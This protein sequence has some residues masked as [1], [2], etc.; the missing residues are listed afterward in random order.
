[1]KLLYEHAK[2]FFFANWFVCNVRCRGEEGKRLSYCKRLFWWTKSEGMIWEVGVW[3]DAIVDESRLTWSMNAYRVISLSNA[4]SI[5]PP[6]LILLYR[7]L[8]FRSALWHVIVFTLYARH[9]R[10]LPVLSSLFDPYCEYGTIVVIREGTTLTY[11]PSSSLS[12]TSRVISCNIALSRKRRYVGNLWGPL[13]L[14]ISRCPSIRNLS[15]IWKNESFFTFTVLENF[16][17]DTG[18]LFQGNRL[19]DCVALYMMRLFRMWLT[20]RSLNSSKL[21]F[22]NSSVK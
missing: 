3:I 11:R 20:N 21:H 7:L 2:A 6:L 9:A 19:T 8:C 18:F 16:Q 17:A 12:S 15:V 14:W 22:A 13:W 10:I 5:L 4:E 1:M